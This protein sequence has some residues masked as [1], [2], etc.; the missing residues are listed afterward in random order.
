MAGLSRDPEVLTWNLQGSCQ[1]CR[2]CCSSDT[3]SSVQHG[4]DCH[5]LSGRLQSVGDSYQL[6]S[7]TRNRL[8]NFERI[9]YVD[10]SYAVKSMS[11]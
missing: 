6:N 1:D 11:P 5:L 7:I 3:R 2:E 10:K 4:M 9:A 8:D